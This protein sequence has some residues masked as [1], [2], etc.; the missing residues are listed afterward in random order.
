MLFET[1]CSLS[2]TVV[3]VCSLGVDTV[4]RSRRRQRQH[5]GSRGDYVTWL[6]ARQQYVCTADTGHVVLGVQCHAR[7]GRHPSTSSGHSSAP[8]RTASRH[9]TTLLLT[10]HTHSQSHPLSAWT[11]LTVVTWRLTVSH[12][13]STNCI[14]PPIFSGRPSPDQAQPGVISGIIGR[15]KIENWSLLKFT[16]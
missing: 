7:H 16:I 6:A 15:L 4:S 8:R 5:A 3:C 2:I 9:D 11:L 1:R 10:S 12:L 13:Q 14:L